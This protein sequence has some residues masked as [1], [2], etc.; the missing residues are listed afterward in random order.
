MH[1]DISEITLSIRRQLKMDTITTQI[2]IRNETKMT[3][4]MSHQNPTLGD[5]IMYGINHPTSSRRPSLS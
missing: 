1:P 5:K 4:Y 2:T 3:E